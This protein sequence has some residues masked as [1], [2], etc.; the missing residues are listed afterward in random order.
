M[1][2][3]STRAVAALEAIEH[4]GTRELSAQELIE[5]LVQ[6]IV[7]VIEVDGFF[8]GATDPDTGFCLGAGMV[9]NYAHEVCNPFWEHEFL[10][11]DFNKFSDLTPA[12]PVADLRLATGG[13]LTRS[14]RY[15]T[16][17]AI[18][19]LAEELRGVFFAGGRPWG[20]LQLSRHDGGAPFSE[21]ER[22][23]LRAVAPLAGAALRRALLEEPARTDPSRGPGVV[24]L[25]ED[26]AV[27]S[28]TGEADAWLAELS[29]GWDHAG[30]DILI[31]PELLLMSLSTLDDGPRRVR[32]RTRNGTWLVAHAAALSGS[33]Q[34]AL[35]IEPAKAS[36]IAPIVVEA[37]GLT[38]R[39]VEVTRLVAR[40]LSTDEIT[41]TLHLSRHTVRDH[42]KAIFEKVGV[43]SR[44]ELTSKLF[45]EHYHPALEGAIQ[46]S[47]ERTA[48]RA[49]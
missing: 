47:W 33:R 37:Y 19:G 38:P 34:V 16:L 9:F 40:G 13:R 17:N 43:S 44:G 6:R 26:G 45:A 30:Y 5:A 20:T 4:L 18:S 27:L 22:A 49:G 8:A 10:V 2:R 1:P 42:L 7:G 12:D 41:A 3:P 36:E 32:L 31:H 35:V 29:S 24:I 39:E 25:G 11:P 48:A 14:A 28:A 21:S 15:R 46:E 23:F